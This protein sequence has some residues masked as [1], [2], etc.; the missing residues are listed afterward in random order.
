[1]HGLLHPGQ[2]HGHCAAVLGAGR[3]GLGAA[4]LLDFLGADVRLVERDPQRIEAAVRQEADEKGWTVRTGGHQ[5][6]DF[7]GVQLV[8]PSPG[9][10]VHRLAHLFPSTVQ[11]VSELELASWFVNEPIVAVTG[12]AGKTTTTTLIAHILETAGYSA[13]SGGNLGTPLSEY[14][15]GREQADF[16]VLEVSSFQLVH[17]SRLRPKVAILLNLAPNHLDYHENLEAYIGAKLKLFAKQQPEDVAIVPYALKEELEKRAFSRAHR[18]YF[19][20]SARFAC[21]QLP[22]EHNQANIEAAYLA[23]RYLGVDEQTIARA[24]PSY[25]PQPHRLEH[26]G[27]WAGVRVVDDS[28]ATTIEALRAALESFEGP[29]VLF[30]GGQ[31]KGGDPGVLQELIRD[32]VK[33][34][35][36][37]GESR[38]VF[39]TAW[40]GAA[41]IAWY[42]RLEQG[43]RAVTP[44]LQAGDILLLSPATASFDLFTD[45]RHRGRV[46]Q[47]TARECLHNSRGTQ[48]NGANGVQ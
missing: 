21:A 42:P 1:M 10:P 43:I 17:A 46:F 13:F 14:V 19:V 37:F 39:E 24:L 47:E 28:K 44:S 7:S 5:E 41:P 3:S 25:Q 11:I 16:L 20:P 32:K 45:Y 6:A 33:Q 22:G 4:R 23:C 40:Q 9:V 26:V 31:F 8:V 30:A 27:T 34:V 48:P 36:L 38:E 15:L 2:L 12:S 29:I 18:M 35:V